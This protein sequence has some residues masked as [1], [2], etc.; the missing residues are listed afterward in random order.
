MRNSV[1]ISYAG[2][3]A[4]LSFVLMY[5]GSVIW[6]FAYIVPQVCGLIMMSV[7]KTFGKKYA[8]CVFFS[9]VILSLLFSPD[10]ESGLVYAFFFGYYPMIKESLEKI[11][12]KA[13]CI[14]VKF[15]IFN[16]GIIT[17]QLMLTYVFGVP[18]DNEL[19]KWGIPLFI[20]LFNVLFVIYERLYNS[21]LYIYSERL[22]KKLNKL[23]KK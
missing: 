3:M 14:F 2:I 6:I 13:I 4:A 15:L 23:L 11:K 16:V 22:E 9:V 10:K 12:P 7:N 19:G 5:L 20:A 18:I 21:I 17:S 8:L 1:K